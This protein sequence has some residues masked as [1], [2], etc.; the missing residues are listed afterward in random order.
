MAIPANELSNWMLKEHEQIHELGRQLREKV[1]APPRGSRAEWITDL[2]RR[3]E[4]FAEHIGRHLKMEEDGGYLTQVVELRPTLSEAVGIIRH[5]HEELGQILRDLRV[6]VREVAPTDV[7][8][9]R[10]CCRRVEHFLTWL[11]RHE[12][13]ENHIML[14]AFTQDIGAGD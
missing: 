9:L 12:E 7:L 10:D 5:E 3:F 6:A 11:E 8:V 13:H 14:Y 4:E 1:A 2:C